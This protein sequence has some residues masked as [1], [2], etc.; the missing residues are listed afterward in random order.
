MEVTARK[1]Q[2]SDGRYLAQV[3]YDSM[4]PGVGHGVFDDALVGAGVDPVTFHEAL[5]LTGAN[6]WGQLDSFIV[7]ETADQPQAGA[8]GYFL[9]SMPDL[10]PLTGQGF[11][12]VS[13]HL[14]WP[15]DVA[16]E[17]W[18][19]YLSFFGL[20]GTAPQ[21]AQPADYV[22]EFSAIDPELR[23]RG[24]YGRL[25]SAHVEQARAM[26]CKTVGGTAILGNDIV[27]R[28]LLKF[29]FREHARFGPEHYRGAFPG[30]TRLVL[31]L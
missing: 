11:K 22:L 3:M 21:L 24:L 17:F 29:G 25:L 12:L 2:D 10:R 14:G 15:P 31:E 16:R 13:D 4:L 20:F 5:L 28:A 30:L 8:M 9:S 1:A 18:R 26:G 6:N 23:G 27:L 19:R 7:L